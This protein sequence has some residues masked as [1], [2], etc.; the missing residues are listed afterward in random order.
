MENNQYETFKDY[1]TTYDREELQSIVDHGCVSGCAGGLIYYRDTL[2]FYDQ[3]CDELHDVLAEDIDQFGET[4]KYITDALAQGC[5]AFKNAL[6]WYV[7][8]TYANQIL[9]ETEAD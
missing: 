9:N 4:P 5:T 3:F 2:A 7:A 8:E 1:M 6:V